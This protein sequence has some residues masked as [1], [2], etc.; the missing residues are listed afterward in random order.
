KPLPR[1]ESSA[2]ST[3]P[4]AL[5]SA[6]VGSG[7]TVDHQLADTAAP[8]PPA[9]P[10]AETLVAPTGDTGVRPVPLAPTAPAA[11]SAPP[12]PEPQPLGGTVLLKDIAPPPAKAAEGGGLGMTMIVSSA[13]LVP[14][15]GGVGTATVAEYRVQPFTS[16]G[17]TRQ[18]QVQLD[19]PSVSRK[20]AQIAL[21]EGSYLLTDLHSENGT[22]VNGEKITEQRLKDGDRLQFGSVR[23][24]FHTS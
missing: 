15:G 6:P 22:F 23:F 21:S 12:A 19:E 2:V 14:L 13:R 16:I 18:N 8:P 7:T 20:H 9:V 24:T 5:E 10:G 17:R 1:S 4:P 11:P 3:P